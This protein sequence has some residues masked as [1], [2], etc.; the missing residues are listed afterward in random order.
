[1]TLLLQQNLG[2]AWGANTAAPTR[3]RRGKR[4]RGRAY[5]QGRHLWWLLVLTGWWA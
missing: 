4:A 5:V 3:T 2:T 1:M